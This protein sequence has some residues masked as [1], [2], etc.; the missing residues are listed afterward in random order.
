MDLLLHY[1][2]AYSPETLLIMPPAWRVATSQQGALFNIVRGSPREQ[3]TGS[4]GNASIRVMRPTRLCLD[5][6]PW[7]VVP[8]ST[9]ISRIHG[10]TLNIKE[11]PW[12]LKPSWT[13]TWNA[14]ME[15]N[16]Q[17][18]RS[19]L[20]FSNVLCQGDDEPRTIATENP[21][22][23]MTTE[24]LG[25]EHESDGKTTCSLLAS[26][27]ARGPSSEFFL[28][29]AGPK[30]RRRFSASVLRRSWWR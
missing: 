23:W 25:P 21:N 24:P 14:F 9:T 10:N 3:A 6:D 5:K 30:T 22:K 4:Y 29:R 16:S 1:P 12:T 26:S 8:K 19:T 18:F 20:Y 27:L 11:Q 15:G 17:K 28:P 2:E 13:N 7:E